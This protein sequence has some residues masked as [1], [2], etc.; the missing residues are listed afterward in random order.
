MRYL[1]PFLLLCGPA[2]A[3]LPTVEGVV[4]TRSH[5]GWTFAVTVRHADEGWDHY[6]DGWTVFAMDGTELGT[7]PLAHPHV[8]E[9]PFT[10]SLGGVA[11]PEGTERVILRAHDAV[12]GWG[13]D[14]PVDLN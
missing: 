10:R 7:R 9:Q 1:T 2:L 13:P 4:A 12:H 8:D 5:D 3:D 11:I 14:T 6:A